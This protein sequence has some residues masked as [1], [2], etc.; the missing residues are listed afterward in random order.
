[1]KEQDLI[2]LGFERHEIRSDEEFPS[3]EYYYYV[4]DFEGID[5]SLISNTDDELVNGEWVVSEFESNRLV[6]TDVDDLTLFI[7]LVEKHIV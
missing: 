7:Q 3:T 5:I 1:M 4:Y 2:N 6:F